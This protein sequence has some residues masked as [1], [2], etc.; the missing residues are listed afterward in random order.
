MCDHW[1]SDS[2]SEVWTVNQL[3]QT[4]GHFAAVADQSNRYTLLFTIDTCHVT[5]YI[6]CCDKNL[7]R[8]PYS[9]PIRNRQS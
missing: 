8:S 1:L 2:A 4:D 6:G 9:R 7:C 5:Q 3:M